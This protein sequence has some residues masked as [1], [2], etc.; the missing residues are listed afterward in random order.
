MTDSDDLVDAGTRRFLS[1]LRELR[2]GQAMKSGEARV[3]ISDR[4]RAAIFD[5][6]AVKGDRAIVSV[7]MLEDPALLAVAPGTL[8]TWFG[9]LHPGHAVAIAI[10]DEL[11]MPIGPATR[12]TFRTPRCRWA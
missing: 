3:V 4:Y 6:G 9:W 5:V 12:P 7:Q 1:E 11:H 8:V 2:D 10:G